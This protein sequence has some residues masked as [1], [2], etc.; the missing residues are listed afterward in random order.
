MITDN[1]LLSVAIDYYINKKTQE[2]IAR[3][4]SVSQVQVGK[5]LKEALRRNIVSITVNL[6]INEDTERNLKGLFKEIFGCKNLVLV[7]GSEN[8]DKSHERVV[9]KAADYIL[10]TYPNRG[11]RIGI[12]WGRTMH[13]L[14]NRKMP[15]EKKSNWEYCPLCILSKSAD[16]AYFDSIALANSAARNWG[17]KV[18]GKLA[19]RLVLYQKLK[20]K[21]LA[22]DCR[23]SWEELD[24]MVCG[25]GC[26][27]SRYP[28]PRQDMFSK[29]VFKEVNMKN[30]VG[31]ILHLFYD[32][33]GK[34]YEANG[35]DLIIPQREIRNIPQRIA[36]ASGFPKV[37]SIIG[38]LRTG[39]VGTLVTDVQTAQHVI[40]YLK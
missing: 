14:M 38:G 18:D 9:A 28:S 25:L 10:E 3:Q 27:S 13:D 21:A 8:S 40:D 17:G 2:E 24:F 30:L 32:I 29:Q 12:G 23:A 20:S 26:S 11:T 35:N 22:D 4:L 5:Y 15:V 6:P 7:Q 19:E 16:N 31:D 34:L 37:E 36:I 1:K 33:D 39:L